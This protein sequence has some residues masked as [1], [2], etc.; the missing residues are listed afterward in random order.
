MIESMK[1]HFAA[2]V[3]VREGNIQAG[4]R[5]QKHVHT[6]DH[7]SILAKG[8]AVVLVEGVMT[9]YIAPQVI[10]IKAN[11]PHEVLAVTDVTWYCIHGTTDEIDDMDTVKITE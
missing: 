8:L 4:M 11:T 10:T 3:Y 2:D 7:V 5:V 6:Y 1:H 9:P